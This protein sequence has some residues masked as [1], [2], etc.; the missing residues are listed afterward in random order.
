LF[1]FFIL[2]TGLL[3]WSASCLDVDRN[4]FAFHMIGKK[5]DVLLTVIDFLKVDHWKVGE[6]L[7]YAV[8]QFC[9]IIQ[10][11]LVLAMLLS[12]HTVVW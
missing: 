2:P 3:K 8:G 10:M 5:C 9:F 4:T 7:Y 6:K 11:S 12:H 1:H